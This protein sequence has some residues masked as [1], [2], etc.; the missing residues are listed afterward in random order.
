M[1]HLNF[2]ALAIALM[3]AEGGI[4]MSD[5]ANR[6]YALAAALDQTGRRNNY[7]L[8]DTTSLQFAS[9]HKFLREHYRDHWPRTR[10]DECLRLWS[11]K[12]GLGKDIELGPG[13][14]F[15]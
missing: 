8:L 10:M 5:D 11:A 12:D 4:V 2:A 14:V 1:R 15:Y 13:L 6:L 3:P 7:V 9:Y